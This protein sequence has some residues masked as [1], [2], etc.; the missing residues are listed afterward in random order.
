MVLKGN[1]PNIHRVVLFFGSSGCSGLRGN[2]PEVHQLLKKRRAA[3]PGA[4][5]S[6]AAQAALASRRTAS[7][8]MAPEVLL[9]RNL[10]PLQNRIWSGLVES[11]RG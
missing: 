10:P 9:T 7:I 3:L 4:W 6:T 11:W 5:R 2:L 1:Q 8:A